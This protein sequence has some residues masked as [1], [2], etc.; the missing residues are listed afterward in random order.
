MKSEYSFTILDRDS[1][2]IQA[3][4]LWLSLFTANVLERACYTCIL[5]FF[6]SD[7]VFRFYNVASAVPFY[8]KCSLQGHQLFPQNYKTN[9]LFWFWFHFSIDI[10]NHDSLLRAIV[11]VPFPTLCLISCLSHITCWSML[12]HQTEK[13]KYES[14]HGRHG[15]WKQKNKTLK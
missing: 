2:K 5:Q 7:S 1:K 12:V 8:W 13:C 3:S 4:V 15:P 10:L 14:I 9:S 6:I 11:S